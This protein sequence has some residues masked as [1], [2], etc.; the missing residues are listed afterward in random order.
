LGGFKPVPAVASAATNATNTLLG[1]VHGS[2]NRASEPVVGQFEILVDLLVG[3]RWSRLAFIPHIIPIEIPGQLPF[4][5]VRK[6]SPK[7]IAVSIRLPPNFYYFFIMPHR[8]V[9]GAAM[10]VTYLNA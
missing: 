3:R 1:R 9:R 10:V 5:P 7:V 8:I 2:D 6:F 4:M